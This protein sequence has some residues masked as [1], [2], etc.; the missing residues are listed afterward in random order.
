MLIFRGEFNQS[1]MREKVKPDQDVSA[2]VSEHENE[3]SQVYSN[4]PPPM[5]HPDEP[6]KVDTRGYHVKEE[7]KKGPDSPMIE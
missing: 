7:V 3:S 4:P 2:G 6:R 1:P 5:K